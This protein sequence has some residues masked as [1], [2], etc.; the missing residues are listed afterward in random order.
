MAEV[1]LALSRDDQRE[2]LEQV[3]AKTVRPTHLL[4]KDVWVA[5]TLGAVF[6]SYQLMQTCS[7]VETQANKA[8]VL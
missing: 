8:A 3:R 2:V 6:D 1:F 4:E 5:W 7:E